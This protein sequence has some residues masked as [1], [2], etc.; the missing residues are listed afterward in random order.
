MPILLMLLV[1]RRSGPTGQS[2]KVMSL[3]GLAIA[4]A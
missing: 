4:S 1:P 3:P 2:K